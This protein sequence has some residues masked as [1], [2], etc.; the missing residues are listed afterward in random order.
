MEGNS[1]ILI[2][3]NPTSGELRIMNYELRIENVEILDMM[4][5]LVF[6]VETHGRASLQSMTQPTTTI[7]IS[8]LP[9]GI[10]F[11]RI[12]ISPPSGGLG[13]AGTV[14]QKIVKH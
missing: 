4:G 7:D 14:T 9:S 5:K 10:Y 3:P 11:I 6:I 2:Y 8:H 13:G 12:Q 1:G